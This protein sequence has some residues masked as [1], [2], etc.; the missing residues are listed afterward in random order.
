MPKTKIETNKTP[1]PRRNFL[2]L[3]LTVCK[4]NTTIK[5]QIHYLSINHPKT[6]KKNCSYLSKKSPFC[7]DLFATIAAVVPYTSYH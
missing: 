4:V 1:R 7:C 5:L 6:L 2:V 3:A